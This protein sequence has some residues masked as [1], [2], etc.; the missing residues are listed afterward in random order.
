MLRWLPENI[1]TYGQD[2]DWLFYLI[3]YITGGVFLLVAGAMV[4]FL[5]LYRHREG[6]RATYTHGNATLE[7]VWTVVP[8]LILV[9]L[10]FLSVPTWGRIKQHLPSSDVHIRI[11]AKQFNWEVTYPGPDGKF[12][13]EDDQTLDNE[14]HIPVGKPA[15]LHLTSKDVIHS[16]FIPQ[17]RLKQD[18]V[19]GRVITQWVQVTKPGKYEIP[20]AELCGFGHSG[21]KGYLF[22]HTLEEYQQ[23]LKEKW[24]S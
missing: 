22:V 15:I 16:V 23:W 6:R 10:T 14:V 19:P 2:V 7:I 18:A 11:T 1:A 4:V 9:V 5:V 24:P 20:C 17:A 21:M 3:Y 12:D 8:A 13:T